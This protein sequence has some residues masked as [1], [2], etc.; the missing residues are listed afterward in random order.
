M[1]GACDVALETCE[2]DPAE[3]FGGG[4]DLVWVWG[5]WVGP[6]CHMTWDTIIQCW[7]ALTCSWMPLG[8]V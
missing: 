7:V 1:P 2:G 5:S 6:W 3:D 4:C 8:I